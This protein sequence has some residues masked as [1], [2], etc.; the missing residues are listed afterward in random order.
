[1][2]AASRVRRMRQRT[3]GEVSQ[4]R[5]SV[6]SSR[7]VWRIPQS[8]CKWGRL[9]RGPGHWK[10]AQAKPKQ[11]SFSSPDAQRTSG[12][13]LILSRNVLA[14]EMSE[15]VPPGT[16]SKMGP[17]DAGEPRG[18]RGPP[19][20]GGP[21]AGRGRCG[22]V[23]F[24]KKTWYS[25]GM[26]SWNFEASSKVSRGNSRSTLSRHWVRAWSMPVG[27]AGECGQRALIGCATP[28]SLK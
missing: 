16:F 7:G 5:K 3:A 10:P 11:N 17:R 8:R 27:Q 1:M 24:V 12:R 26:E 4:A 18:G 13:G 9:Q 25:G 19:L 28:P 14:L 22:G 6:I 15:S 23:A 21:G 20:L 2:S